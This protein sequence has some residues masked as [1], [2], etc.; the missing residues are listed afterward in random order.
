M[1]DPR[2]MPVITFKHVYEDGISSFTEPFCF[3][4][5]DDVNTLLDDIPAG[6]FSAA[7]LLGYFNQLTGIID[8]SDLSE[9][10]DDITDHFGYFKPDIES[11]VFIDEK[12]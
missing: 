3:R 1:T 8:C 6:T 9:E 7:Y 10:R 2:K 11:E 12:T 5:L 4:S